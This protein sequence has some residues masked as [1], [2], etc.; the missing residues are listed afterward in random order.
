[1]RGWL[2]LGGHGRLGSALMQVAPPGSLAP[3]SSELDLR[4]SKSVAEQLDQG[5][6][7]RVIN[8]AAL[9]DVDRCERDRELA[10]ELNGRAVGRLAAICRERALQLTQVSTDYVLSGESELRE[11]DQPQPYNAYGQS[12]ALGEALCMEASDSHLVVRVQW[13]FGGGQGDFIRFVRNQALAGKEI[14][15]I[16]DQISIPSYTPD[17]AAWMLL[18]FRSQAKGIV[19]LANG[20]TTSRWE[21]ALSICDALGVE[22]RLTPTTWAQLGRSAVRPRRSVLDTA[23]A[24]ALTGHLSEVER[25]VCDQEGGLRVFLTDAAE[26]RPWQEAQA[27]W[28]EQLAC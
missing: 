8:C 28:L 5:A 25:Q 21:Q 22:P 14:P 27:E 23:H 2:V 24:V 12:K 11:T 3:R 26:P 9:T 10:D 16:Q 19:H 18:L 17:L 13:L 1:M 15:V 20:G 4:N 7:E 6:F